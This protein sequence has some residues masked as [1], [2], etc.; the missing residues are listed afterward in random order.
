MRKLRHG[1]SMSFSLDNG[2]NKDESQDINPDR[3]A[4]EPKFLTSNGKE[5]VYTPKEVTMNSFHIL[6]MVSVFQKK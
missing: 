1:A 5:S 4:P 2:S 3:R 6:A